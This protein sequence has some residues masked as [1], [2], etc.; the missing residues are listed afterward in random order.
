M[1][2][3]KFESMGLISKKNAAMGR[4]PELNLPG[5]GDFSRDQSNVH[6]SSCN[7]QD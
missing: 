4:H 2:V 1:K 5:M 7:I 3:L 6:L